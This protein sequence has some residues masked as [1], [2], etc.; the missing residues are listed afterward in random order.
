MWMYVVIFIVLLVTELAY[1]RIAKRFGIVDKPSVRSSHSSAV[2]RGGGVIIPLSMLLWAVL[3]GLMNA[4]SLAIDFWPFLIGLL[5]VAVTGFVDD[6]RPLPAT[7]RLV[8]LFLVAGMLLGQLMTENG[9][10]YVDHWFNWLAVFVIALILFVGI[11]NI[12]NFMDGI[13]GITSVYSLV[14][15][16]SLLILNKRADVP[17]I[18]SSYLWV[19]ALG[20]LVFGLFNFRPKGNAKCFGG[21]VGSLSIGFIMVFAVSRLIRQTGDVTWLMLL[22]VYGVDGGLTI[23]HRLMLHENLSIA[24]RK[25]AYQLMA[26]ELGMDHRVVAVLYAAMQ[27]G[28]SLVAIYV[29]PD[30]Q[31][32]RWI[33]LVSVGLALSVA[34]VVFMKKYYHLHEAYLERQQERQQEGKE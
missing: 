32:A 27:A 20:V 7:L 2:L 29:I 3:L 12:V 1:F 8:I 9:G 11:V 33:Y 19:G 24:H 6:V 14:V 18:P 28:V 31:M 10:L 5:L 25:H 17:F 4:G 13:N 15:L 26:N 22:M 30:T 21:D 34:Y 16:L 23:V